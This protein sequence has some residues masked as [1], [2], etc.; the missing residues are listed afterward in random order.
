MR[1]GGTEQH[2]RTFML[3]L[4]FV[5][6][7]RGHRQIHEDTVRSQYGDQLTALLCAQL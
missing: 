7:K 1:A 5:C 6:I 3:S 2:Y 4:H